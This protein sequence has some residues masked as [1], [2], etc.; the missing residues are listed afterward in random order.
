MKAA[1]RQFSGQIT[2]EMNRVIAGE[3]SDKVFGKGG[4]LGGAGGLFADAF[5]PE[6][7]ASGLL[8]ALKPSSDTSAVTAS[9]ASLQTTGI[10][11]AT[12]AFARLTA[13]V[14]RA[15]GAVGRNPGETVPGASGPLFAGTAAEAGRSGEQ[16]IANL[17]KAP[18]KDAAGLGAS[19]VDV[20][21]SAQRFGDI[22]G[23]ASGVLAGLAREGS[24]A[25][26]ALRLLP[27]LIQAAGA[28]SGGKGIGGAVGSLFGSAGGSNLGTIFG[29]G[30]SS[31]GIGFGT[32]FGFG[33]EDLGLFFHKGGIVG[34]T[35]DKR[36]VASG[37]FAEAAKYHSGGL[38]GKAADQAKGLA[39]NE[40][41][42]ILLGGP[43][44]VREE[45]LKASDPRHRDNHGAALLQIIQG[46]AG[47]KG[48]SAF[49]SAFAKGG[50]GKAMTGLASITNLF[51]D[52]RKYHTGGI[53]GQKPDGLAVN[54][55]PIL[56]ASAAPRYLMAPKPA[57]DEG[58]AAPAGA[59]KTV[60]VNLVQNFAK[61]VGRDTI[62]QAAAASARE[63]QIAGARG[64]N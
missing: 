58:K 2:G 7:G 14:D 38:V 30:S 63:L 51:T 56:R 31:G 6:K 13:E 20:R 45:V 26:S 60:N 5:R 39:A 9:F 44:G 28:A 18:A 54:V 48:G 25:A 52:A 33:N 49:A 16:S 43:K 64:F 42:A 15:A 10:D 50:D 37:V 11:P 46:A 59:N 55:S 34:Q 27:A 36:P 41:P 3:L 22:L 61:G 4:V 12:S 35:V 47:G 29:G 19:L 40:V 53:A 17:F 8:G 24:G 21:T 32:G 57:S 1:L 62:N 23:P